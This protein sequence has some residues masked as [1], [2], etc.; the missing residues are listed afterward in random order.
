[1][2]AKT[3]RLQTSQKREIYFC[4]ALDIVSEPKKQKAI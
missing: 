2:G 3:L 1:M 4:D